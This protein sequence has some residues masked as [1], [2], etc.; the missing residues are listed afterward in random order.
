MKSYLFA[1]SFTVKLNILN[2]NLSQTIFVNDLAHIKKARN[3]D[4][5]EVFTS[6]LIESRYYS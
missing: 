6:S 3:A 2:L 1:E 5:T 4:D